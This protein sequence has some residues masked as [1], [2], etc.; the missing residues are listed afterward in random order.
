VV[1]EQRV[2]KWMKV[3][4][5]LAGGIGV[6]AFFLP[7]VTFDLTD[8]KVDA[9]AYQFAS[10]TGDPLIDK[11][12]SGQNPM[13]A[14]DQS[15]SEWFCDYDALPSTHSLVP[16]HFLSTLA[17]LLTAMHAIWR[18]RMDVI[19]GLTVIASSLFAIGILLHDVNSEANYGVVH[20][21][22]L[23]AILLGLSGLLA[24]GPG[25]AIIYW[26][27]PDP[28]PLFKIRVPA[29]RVVRR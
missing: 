1:Y 24:I 25:I 26:R 21:T 17:F 13:C 19:G 4:V 27:E 23:G 22:G 14:K 6:L 12:A 3:V 7:Y 15:S 29:A 28:V 11:L 20:S 2:L 9:S 8:R 18:K 10:Q 5:L 16:L